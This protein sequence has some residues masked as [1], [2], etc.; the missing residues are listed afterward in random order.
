MV[1]ISRSAGIDPRVSKVLDQ[2][3]KRAE[4]IESDTERAWVLRSG[5]DHLY[6]ALS[7]S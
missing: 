4:G 1:S 6:A 3:V 7:E 2:L 5:L